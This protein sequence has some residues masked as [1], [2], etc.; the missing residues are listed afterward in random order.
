VIVTPAADA[1]RVLAACQAHALGRHA[2]AI[3]RVTDVTPPL[4]ELVSRV[5]GRR[6]VQRPYGEELP[7]I[8]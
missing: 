5:G 3:G 7:R 2:A 1:Q 8:C 4:V 6:L